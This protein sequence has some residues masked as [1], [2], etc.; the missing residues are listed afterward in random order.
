[1]NESLDTRIRNAP[2]V[3]S[4]LGKCRELRN[5]AIEIDAT[6]TRRL[7][8]IVDWAELSKE[9]SCFKEAELPDSAREVKWG[10][11]G[12]TR[13]ETTYGYPL[14]VQGRLDTAIKTL[15][16]DPTSRA[17]HIQI[18]YLP[19]EQPC[20]TSFN[21]AIREKQLVSTV[22]FRSMDWVSGYP[23]D[24][25]IFYHLFHVESW[26]KIERELEITLGPMVFFVTSLHLYESDE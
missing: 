8:E 6:E 1:M 7:S 5:V 24:A 26:I 20:A 21:L 18:D 22:T 25:L 17:A 4:R 3:D 10:L 19:G 15:I 13:Q 12:K 16:A 14:Y 9:L 11:R 23:Y 2:Y